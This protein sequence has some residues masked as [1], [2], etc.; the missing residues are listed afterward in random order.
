[1]NDRRIRFVA[2]SSFLLAVSLVGS[3]AAR[4]AGAR[5]IPTL[6]PGGA[7]PEAPDTLV[8]ELPVR[9][10]PSLLALRASGPL[11]PPDPG[12]APSAHPPTLLRAFASVPA[13]GSPAVDSTAAR[14]TVGSVDPRSDAIVFS[15]LK[16]FSV[17]MGTNRDATLE[18]SLDL[19]VRGRVAGDVEL[20]ATLSDRQ[21]PFEPDGSSRELED[22]DR[23]ALS[24]RAPRAEA[25]MGDFALDGIPGE[26]ARMSRQ[27]EGVRGFARTGDTRWNVAAA[28]AKGERRTLE[29]RGEEGRQGPYALLS[30]TWAEDQNGVV[31][32]SEVVWLDGSRMRRGADEDYVVDYGAGTVTFTVRRPITAQSRIAVDFEAGSSRYKRTLY[33]A[34]SQGG[35]PGGGAWHASYV[36]EGDDSGS[37]LGAELTEQ[38]KEALSQ[39]GDSATTSSTLPSGVTYQGPGKG[40]YAWDESNPASPRWVY[41]GPS[42]GDFDVEFA[43][44]GPGR[45]AYAD[46]TGIE[47]ERFYRYRGESLGEYVPGRAVAVPSSRSLMDVGGSARLFGSLSLDAEVA[48]SALDPNA[49]SSR[50]DADNGGMAARFVARLEPRS[51]SIGGLGL[52]RLRAEALV[53]SRG[54]RFRAFDRI[55]PAFESERW[56]QAPSEGG[57]DR[58]E[59]SLR[60][61]PVGV[62]ALGG[63]FG[64]RSL[65]GG[66]R[67]IRQG[68]HAEIR[69]FLI[70]AARWDEARNSHGAESGYRSTWTLDLSRATGVILPR[71]AAR[72]ERIRGQEGDSASA[73]ESREVTVGLGIAPS[74]GLRLRGGYGVRDGRVWESALDPG[75]PER[76]ETWEGGVS[77]RTGASFSVEG[78][79]TSRRAR[80]GTEDQTTHLAQL[81]VTGGAPGGPVTSELRYDVTQL[82]EAAQV[83]E[84]RPVAEGSGSYDVYGNPRLGGGFE[85]VTTAGDPSTRSRAVVQLRLDTYPAR[86]RLAPGKRAGLHR[87][88]GGSTFFRVETLSRLPLGSLEHALDPHAYLS[89]E[90]T[91][92]GTMTARQT[93]EIAPPG[94]RADARAEVGFRRD[95]SSE[96]E[97]LASTRDAVDARATLRHPIP[98]G[99]RGSITVSMD[100]AV[101]S[102]ARTDSIGGY[103]S[104]VRGQGLEAEISREIRGLG[105]VSILARRREDFDVTGG[106]SYSLWSAG[107]T[108]RYAAG[109]RVRLD[110]RVLWGT[111][112]QQGVYAPPGLYI[113]APVGAR[114]DYDLTGEY[115]MRDRIALSFGWTGYK[116]RDRAAYYTGRVELKGS[117]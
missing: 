43:S 81:A 55:D 64:H 20:A 1:M 80:S 57:E 99:L 8:I 106:G 40:S 23:I 117:F 108:A 50:D 70:G 35:I 54:D 95:R 76:A 45:G 16:T 27:L 38:D 5:P 87:A 100:H 59:V 62:L 11:A 101:Q 88:L 92:R 44:V 47:G 3:F 29:F 111:T 41:L 86:A 18:Q 94:I 112:E 66:S 15:G 12:T 90:N 9:R 72:E 32:G 114:L 103:E 36:S 71:V 25:T 91:L 26:F 68:A 7:P 75:V 24:V 33:A 53:R 78:G 51:L 46:T 49:L 83:R 42:H 39:A 113:A 61:E 28:G 6:Y 74:A 77:A 2:A 96:I 104:T 17:E 84:L 63:E 13:A 19:T 67:S 102:V 34:T 79:Y 116:T 105:Q 109:S 73:R 31:S 48:R 4:P 58:Q 69:S 89:A 56:N 30:R 115:R 14:G 107:P 52:G 82:R 110:A 97:A 65:A 22:L 98:A 60:Y 10:S 93:L 21:L 85:L 37:P